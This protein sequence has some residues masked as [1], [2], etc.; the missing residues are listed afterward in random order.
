MIV[1]PK[2]LIAPQLYRIA[3]VN[4][5][6]AELKPL[7]LGTVA[8]QSPLS[9]L[10]RYRIRTTDEVTAREQAVTVLRILDPLADDVFE[11][12]V[13]DEEGETMTVSE[14]DLQVHEGSAAP[15]VE[16]M[17]IQRDAAPWHLVSARIRLLESFFAAT[18]RSLG[19]VGYN[20]ARMLPI[21]HQINAARYALQ[22]GRIRFLL[23]DEVGLGKTVEAGLIVSTLRKYFPD[24]ETAIFVPESLQA[25][26]AFEMYGKF[27]KIIFSLGEEM[28]DE[29]E[30]D[31]EEVG[32]I[33]PHGKAADFAERRSPEI[34]VVD[35]AH[36]ILHDERAVE[37]LT[38]LS[39][40]A[41]AVLLLTATPVSD[42]VRNLMTLFQVLDPENYADLANAD[43]MRRLRDAEPA[44]EKFLAQ[45]RQPN[46]DPLAAR[47]AWKATAIID[48]EVDAHLN[49]AADGGDNLSP[50]GADVAR[51]QLHV[52]ASLV[53]DRYYPGSRMLRYRRKFL[54]QDNPL[55]LR[56][57]GTVDYKTTPDEDRAI[58]CMRQWLDLARD[59]DNSSDEQTQRVAAALIQ[60][61]HSSPLALLDWIA[62]RRGTLEPPE[63]RVT[64]D[65]IHL[66]RGAMRA[67]PMLPGEDEVLAQMEI[68]A[69]RWQRFSRAVDATLRPLAET[70]RF[71]AFLQF[72][73]E[74]LE[75]DPD[76]HFLVFTSFESNVRPLYLLV[77]K[78][79][80]DLAEVFEMSGL[81]KRIEREKSA[82]EFQEFP[83]GSVLISDELGGEGRNFQFATHVIHY[84]LPLAPWMVEQRIGRCDRVGRAEEMDVD[85][86]V[87]VAKGQLDEV[88]FDFLS[89][90]VG[91]FNE[92]I[93]PV[94][95]ELDDVTTRMMQVCIDDG[96][97]GVLDLVEE[98][99]THLEAA[100][101]RENAGLLV[102]GAVGVQEARRIA[103]ELNDEAELQSLRREVVNYARLFDSMVDE[104]EGGRLA[105]TVGEYHSLHAV[106][107][108]RAEM[109]GYFD[110]RQAVRHERLDFFSPGHP[111]VRTM[112]Q[113]AM[114]ESPDRVAYVRRTGIREPALVCGFRI[115]LPVEFFAMVRRLPVDL[116]PPLLSRSAY[117]F[118]TRMLRVAV[119]LEGNVITRDK[120]H[121]AYYEEAREGDSSLDERRDLPDILGP[122]WE[123]AATALVS[124]ARETAEEL[125]DL[126]MEEK[127][128]DFEDLLCEV[129]TRVSPSQE[130]AESEIESIMQELGA[131]DVDLDS[132]V[133]LIPG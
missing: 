54:A 90:G 22:F 95:A 101:E 7:S 74:T 63:H 57:V 19:I 117:L 2:G 116:Q 111:F 38:E 33:L 76:S 10:R 53:V 18:R 130:V 87:L 17:L 9:D 12:E 56:V 20:G 127:R 32:F 131:L 26:W 13:E 11:Y 36:R 126:D 14:Y 92:S 59:A 52:A 125:A 85:S 103:S 5:T 30:E 44:I 68:V 67:L 81:Q 72:L 21:A 106:A 43:A 65:P 119:S 62:Q 104:Q 25:Q 29:E 1:Y 77:K 78:A 49:Q 75:D 97:S 96:S 122:D 41:H 69:T 109:I 70:P 79:L 27:G 37:A 60:A 66:A 31:G 6:I 102:R 118:S 23:A 89:E 114:V 64:A 58:A 71:K 3:E 107:G 45:I 42:D 46:P 132:A 40:N 15:D 93:A 99:A 133:Y 48:D 115:A 98:V 51:H 100:R 86:Q 8:Q 55:P 120:A 82:F 121:A 124:K 39:R 105:I 88:I 91:V 123:E 112:A 80:T 28:T 94:E 50:S 108:V 4:Q 128:A 34:L 73:R 113:M 84:D 16:N 129:Y 110:R 24:W 47:K 35:E 61:T 83:A